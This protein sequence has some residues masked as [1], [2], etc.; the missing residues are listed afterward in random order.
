[1]MKKTLTIS[2]SVAIFLAI[3]LIEWYTPIHSDDYH[4]TLLGISLD[5]H[6][7]HYMTWSGRVVADYI[8]TLLLFINSRIVYSISIATA[9]L[10]FCLFIA[11][12]P[13]GSFKWNKNDNIIIPLVFLTYWIANP[14]IGETIFWVVGSA[15]YHWTNLFVA[16]WI[17][18]ISYTLQNN[19]KKIRILMVIISLLAGCSNES[20]APFVIG[21]SLLAICYD[22]WK[23]KSTNINKVIYAFMTIVGAC[24]LI[25]APGNFIRA[26]ETPVWLGKSFLEKI[27]FHFTERLSGHLALIW[28]SYVVLAL[29]ALIAVISARK[30]TPVSRTRIYATYLMIA[31]AVGTSFIMFISPSYP[32]R[33]VNGTLMFLLFAI[34]FLGHGIL[35]TA[36]RRNLLNISIVTFLCLATFLWSYSLMYNAYTRVYVQDKVRMKIIADEIAKNQVSFS[37]PEFYFSKLQNSGGHFGL[38]H[39]PNLYGRYFGAKE[40]FKT[41]VKF[42]Y[43]VMYSGQER[44]LDDH[45]RYYTN[46]SGDFMLVSTKPLEGEMTITLNGNTVSYTLETFAK[47]TVNDEYWYYKK[48]PKGQFD[49]VNIVK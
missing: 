27:V 14:N 28:I 35:E 7:T 2:I 6:Y 4:Y 40:I 43:S 24:V 13:S 45:T 39:A 9:V 42:D 23:R 3:F 44:V 21:L 12:T 11:K 31:I 1:M 41:I 47:A 38:F 10:S 37:I 33:V 22:F 48:M 17:Y 36:D 32:D 29:L 19:D 34:A 20:V 5:T 26:K 8:S 46:Q 15:N 30:G 16:A 49:T 18:G 25:L